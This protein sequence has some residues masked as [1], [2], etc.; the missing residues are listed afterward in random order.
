MRTRRRWLAAAI[1]T[2]L[3]TTA[4]GGDDDAVDT[5]AT[6]S[7]ADTTKPWPTFTSNV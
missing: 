3:V 1:C 5:P 4:C 7:T 2:A 6:A